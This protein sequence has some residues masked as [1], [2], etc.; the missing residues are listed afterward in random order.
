M[1][2]IYPNS[3]QY[4]LSSQQVFM[5]DYVFPVAIYILYTVYIYKSKK[6]KKKN[7]TEYLIIYE[8]RVVPEGCVNFY[9]NICRNKK[10]L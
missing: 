3:K 4:N 7:E 8:L 9:C 6:T 10:K 2:C 1:Y 5:Q